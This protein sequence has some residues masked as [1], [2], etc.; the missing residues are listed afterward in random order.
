MMTKQWF[1][2]V[3]ERA[4]ELDMTLEELARRAKLDRSYFRKISKRPGALPK[5][6]TLNAI[7]RQLHVYPDWILG[8]ER[9]EMPAP[10]GSPVAAPFVTVPEIDGKGGAGASSG[11][12]MVSYE[13][14]EGEFYQARD[15][16]KD[17]WGIPSSFLR[18]EARIHERAANVL[19]VVGDS[20]IDPE[21][22]N[23][24]GSLMPGDRAVI[25]T[26]D[27]TP[28]PPGAFAVWDGFGIVFKMVEIV[29]GSNPPKLRLTS[30]NPAYQPYEVMLEEANI[31][32]RVKAR[33]TVY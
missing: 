19:E 33:V 6:E 12:A 7:A 25:D 24:V 30:R 3:K 16:V 28:S 11:E 15:G 29:H 31:I 2:R 10:P 23:A 18:Y 27:R 26:F 17:Q 32:G 14:K 8:V 4:S 1:E 5:T 13:Y 22:P 20:M 21:H 9:A